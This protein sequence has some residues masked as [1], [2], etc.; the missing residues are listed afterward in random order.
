MFLL[1]PGPATRLPRVYLAEYYL[2][3]VGVATAFFGGMEDCIE[4]VRQLDS[5]TVRR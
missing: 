4:T 1:P 3:Y 5:K 2:V